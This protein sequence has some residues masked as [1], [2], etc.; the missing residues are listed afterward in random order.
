[1][2][3]SEYDIGRVQQA[4]AL[5]GNGLNTLEKGDTV[6]C[7]IDML[8]VIDYKQQCTEREKEILH[9]SPIWHL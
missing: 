2:I 5:N 1:M 6:D 9:C 4:K 3:P 8:G 7:Y